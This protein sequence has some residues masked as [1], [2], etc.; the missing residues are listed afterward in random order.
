[1]I[2]KFYTALAVRCICLTALAQPVSAAGT[3]Y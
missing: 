1:M 3:L 2:K